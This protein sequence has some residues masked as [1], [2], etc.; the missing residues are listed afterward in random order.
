MS[1][2]F[3]QR[4]VGQSSNLQ[5]L[6]QAYVLPRVKLGKSSARSSIHPPVY[7][8]V[9]FPFVHTRTGLRIE[10]SLVSRGVWN[11][12][13]PT[14]DG[15]IRRLHTRTSTYQWACSRSLCS[16]RWSE[17]R[18]TAPAY[19]WAEWPTHHPGRALSM[20]RTLEL[21][22]KNNLYRAG[23]K[24]AREKNKTNKMCTRVW[25]MCVRTWLRDP[26]A[27]ET[28]LDAPKNPST[29]GHSVPL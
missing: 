4:I 12:N 9:R 28:W 16:F 25:I 20:R 15:C 22:E 1:R 2:G 13:R 24:S 11:R 23:E 18:H 21:W 3:M 27:A 10:P 26:D 5:E 6:S 8:S 7:S 29:N 19:R 14:K 17:H